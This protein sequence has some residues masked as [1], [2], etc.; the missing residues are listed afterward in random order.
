MQSPVGKLNSNCR[1]AVTSAVLYVVAKRR[2]WAVRE[3]LRQTARK[4]TDKVLT[5]LTPRF[6]RSARE[7]KSHPL[8][9]P[10]IGGHR[11]TRERNI[12]AKTQ[13][14]S[15]GSTRKNQDSKQEKVDLERGD[16]MQ[17]VKN[18]NDDDLSAEEKAELNSSVSPP[19]RSWDTRLAF[20]RR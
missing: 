2:Q 9:T 3:K 13:S 16:K 19:K 14:T 6:P 20:W 18:T 7:P 10:K 11:G 15:C 8:E 4:V 12:L 1:F 5:P 17:S